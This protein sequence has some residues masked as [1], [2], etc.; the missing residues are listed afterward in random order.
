MEQSTVQPLQHR[1]KRAPQSSVG[2]N[3]E[4]ADNTRQ[5]KSRKG[6]FLSPVLFYCKQ[7]F[8]RAVLVEGKFLVLMKSLCRM[9]DM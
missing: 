3:L 8:Q 7:S 1:R 6:G 9:P 5:P 2:K 4:H